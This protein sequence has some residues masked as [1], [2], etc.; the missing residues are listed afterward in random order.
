VILLCVK[1]NRLFFICQMQHAINFRSCRHLYIFVLFI[2]QG[3][4]HNLYC[5][6][7]ISR[8]ACSLSISVLKNCKSLIVTMSTRAK[9]CGPLK[10]LVTTE[11]HIYVGFAFERLQ[12]QIPR[13]AILFVQFFPQSRHA[14]A[15]MV[16]SNEALAHSCP[17]SFPLP[18]H[19]LCHRYLKPIQWIQIQSSFILGKD[20]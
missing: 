14:N 17:P 4:K 13:P 3:L 2:I 6:W 9:M 12:V 15:G 8:M 11:V 1:K 18:Y 20:I 19:R 7:L 5:T 16:P 10:I